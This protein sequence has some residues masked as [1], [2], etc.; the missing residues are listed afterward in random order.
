MSLNG[1][2]TGPFQP[3]CHWCKLPVI[4]LA[5][6]THPVHSDWPQLEPGAGVVVCGL[7]CEARPDGAP[8]GAH[9]KGQT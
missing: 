3:V 2:R 8:V 1:R 7:T 5:A 9:R 4:S 6:V